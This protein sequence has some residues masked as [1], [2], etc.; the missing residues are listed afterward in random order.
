M[1]FKP[2][3]VPL[4]AY[5]KQNRIREW[6]IRV[7][8]C[9]TYS[10]IVTLFG[11][12]DG[13][14]VETIQ[15]VLQGKNLGKKNET[16][17]YQQA[18]LEAQS[19]WNKKK[20]K[21]GYRI[22]EHF[23]NQ[24]NKKLEQKTL[25]KVS[26][27]LAQD[28]KKYKNKVKFPCYVQPKLDGYRCLFYRDHLKLMSRQNKEFTIIKE[29]HKELLKE[30][31]T[32]PKEVIYDGELYVH[33]ISGITFEDLGVLRKK[34]NMTRQDIHNLTNIKYYIYDIVDFS[35]TYEK[36]LNL[37]LTLQKNYK[38]IEFVSTLLINN[39]NEL[40]QLHKQHL[41]DNYEG[42]MIRNKSGMYISYRSVDLLKYKNFDDAEFPIVDFTF[43]MYNNEKLIVWIIQVNQE[44]NILC[45]VR[46]QGSYEERSELYKRGK[47]FIGKKLWTKFFGF[48]EKGSLRF[49]STQR[50]TYMTYIRDNIE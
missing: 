1:N 23:F 5:D 30:L 11:V 6:I 38:Y 19:K 45:D 31:E 35:L 16:T 49:P 20:D 29:Y 15:E 42:T 43:E 40:D 12:K 36:R 24:E 17:H 37:L 28:Y 48:T 41:D 2:M 46:P 18:I 25:Q 26:P 27:M 34:K 21:E 8:D 50:G 39:T 10:E 13:N 3:F 4:Y 47:E 44:K 22:S 7:K 33:S 32:L 14:M 9:N